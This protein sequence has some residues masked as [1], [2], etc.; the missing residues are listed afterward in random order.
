VWFAFVQILTIFQHPNAKTSCMA[1]FFARKNMLATSQ[2]SFFFSLL[3]SSPN[4][5]IL[6]QDVEKSSAQRRASHQGKAS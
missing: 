4:K 5:T 2:A 3:E 6:S 1:S